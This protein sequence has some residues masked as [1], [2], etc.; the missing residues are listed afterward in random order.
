MWRKLLPVALITVS[1]LAPL[2]A[3]AEQ[4]LSLTSVTVDLPFGDRTFP[5]GPG[6]DLVNSNCLAC[7]SAGMVLNQPALTKAQW[8]TEVEKMRTA[9]KA[10]IDPKDLDAI[11]D[12]L[13]G[14]RRSPK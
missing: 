11:V 8:R 10:P 1:V 12:Y 13:T 14:L 3:H 2:A 9:Y 5:D 4:K 7:H 6:A